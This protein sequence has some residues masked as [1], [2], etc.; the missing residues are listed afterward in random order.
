MVQS[1]IQYIEKELDNKSSQQSPVFYITYGPPASGKGGI[2]KKVL[3]KDN[4]DPNTLINVIV[5]EIVSS[6]PG[7]EE[8]RD[9]L[10][11]KGASKQEMQSLYWETRRSAD[12]ISTALLN[13]AIL[14]RF[15]IAW[16]TTGKTIAWTVREVKRIQ[17][18]NYDTV[19]LYPWVPIYSKING[20]PGF[21]TPEE[22]KTMCPPGSLADGSGL[23]DRAQWR[24]QCFGQEAAPASQIIDDAEKAQKN[25]IKL[26]HV[27]DKIYLYDN[28]GGFGEDRLI[29][30][31]ENIYEWTPDENPYEGFMISENNKFWASPGHSYLVHC[32]VN[33]E[34]IKV[35][36]GKGMDK[37][38]FDILNKFCCESI[39]V[40][41]LI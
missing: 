12:S 38:L 5:D 23:L 13:T 20:S 41:D 2:M 21:R 14:N 15:N 39:F 31:I 8:Q 28:S 18:Q 16:E 10:I 6:T 36:E 3:E 29:F 30:S 19:I 1:N 7:Y 37:E 11:A 34:D 24:E 4:I 32:F 33:C 35:L 25:I 22:L 17:R 26:L 27:V 9:K 40:E